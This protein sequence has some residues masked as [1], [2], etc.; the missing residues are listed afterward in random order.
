[1]NV[2]GVTLTL[3]LLSWYCHL[4]LMV[5][6]RLLLCTVLLLRTVS[7]IAHCPAFCSPLMR[8]VILLR[9]VLLFRIVSVVVHCSTGAAVLLSPTTDAVTLQSATD[10]ITCPLLML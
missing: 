3:M 2:T 9:T 5:L 1:M 7:A 10:A 8:T 6:P 4:S